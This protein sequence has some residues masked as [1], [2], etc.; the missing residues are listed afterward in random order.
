MTG[1]AA[2]VE[3]A[4]SALFWFCA[5]R[6]TKRL[7]VQ[8]LSARPVSLGF[9]IRL[10]VVAS[11]R[12]VT[13]R[14]TGRSPAMLIAIWCAAAVCA[15]LLRARLGWF[16][17]QGA[18]VGLGAALG[19]AAGNLLDLAR[20]RPIVDFVDLGWWPVFNTA[21]IAIVVGLIA[22]FLMRG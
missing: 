15:I 14:A 2:V 22:A 6:L 8:R 18:V 11:A 4:A 20:Q 21:D 9:G 12:R 16:V 3:A 7:A 1:A 13:G 17:S 19:G 10:R 5:D